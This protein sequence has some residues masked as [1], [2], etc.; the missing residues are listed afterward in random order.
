MA[1]LEPRWRSWSQDEATMAQ[2]WS[3]DGQ[4]G[5]KKGGILSPALPLYCTPPPSSDSSPL[6]KPLRVL[7]QTPH[8][9]A[10]AELSGT[11]D[12]CPV[13]AADIC[14]VSTADICP[15][16]TADIY[17]VSTEDGTA[18]G[19]RPVAVLYSRIDVFCGDRTDVCCSGKLWLCLGVRWYEVAP[20]GV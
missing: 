18:A 13:S 10:R 16:S 20:A 14:P 8:A 4:V 11:A 6:V 3:Q 19:R 15:V 1:K 5:A 7:P 17:P 12:I 9:Q 2:S